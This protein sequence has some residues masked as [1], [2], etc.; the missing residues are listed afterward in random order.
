MHR[1]VDA[2]HL[3]ELTSLQRDANDT[4]VNNWGGAATLGDKDFSNE[5]ITHALVELRISIRQ[6]S[7][8]WVT[9]K[10][11]TENKTPADA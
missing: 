7:K 1:S 5:T 10:S 3:G 11:E 9:K 8:I 4:L 6:Q 2:S